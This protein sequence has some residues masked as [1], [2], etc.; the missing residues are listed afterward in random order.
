MQVT[1]LNK[2]LEVAGGAAATGLVDGTLTLMLSG[3]W[4]DVDA[5]F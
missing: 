5:V 2:M 3:Y 4:N 1:Y